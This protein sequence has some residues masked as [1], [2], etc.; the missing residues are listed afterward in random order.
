MKIPPDS[1]LK[2]ILVANGKFCS[3]SKYPRPE[4]LG[5]DHR[6]LN[7]G[8]HPKEFGEAIGRGAVWK[9]EI[10]NCA[11]DG[12]FSRVDTTI[13]PARVPGCR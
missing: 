9:R 13:M 8:F 3:L 12:S 6:I 11:R 5:Q 7:S 1:P 4:W 10:K 2:K